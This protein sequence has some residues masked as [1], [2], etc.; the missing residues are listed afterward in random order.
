M[1]V[2]AATVASAF[3]GKK[4]R[5][6]PSDF[7]PD[8]DSHSK[9][10]D[11]RDQIAVARQWTKLLGGTIGGTDGGDLRPPDPRRD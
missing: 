5:V 6:K 4:R 1:G 9:P 7:I 8:W 11:M 2:I 10:Q 3:G